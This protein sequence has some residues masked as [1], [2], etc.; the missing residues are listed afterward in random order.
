MHWQ[1][2]AGIDWFLSPE[3]WPIVFE[4][5]LGIGMV[6][7]VHELGHF[8]VAKACGVKCEKFYLGFDIGGWKLFKYKWG[9]TEYGIGVLPL[10][11]YVKMLGQDD[12]PNRLH[13]E[14][15]RAKLKSAEGEATADQAA[16][17]DSIFDPRSYLAK[18][19]PQ[20]MAI[21]SAGVIMNVIFAFVVGSIAFGLGVEQIACV[22]GK[23]F[24]GEPAWKAGLREGDTVVQIGDVKN[25]VFRDLQTG[26]ALG[27]NID[28]GVDFVVRRPGVDEP[29]K[30][31]IFP[32]R[33]KLIPL[34]GMTNGHTNQVALVLPGTFSTAKPESNAAGLKAGDR[35]VAVNGTKVAEGWQFDRALA[36]HP[37]TATLTV[38]RRQNKPS[39][40]EKKDQEPA[41]DRLEVELPAAPMRTLP[42][43][44]AMGKI[45]AVQ[46]G[47]PA[48]AADIRPD[49]LI[50]EIDGQDAGDPLRLAERLRQ[51]ED[52]AAKITI[53]RS[54][55]TLTKDV[56]LDLN[57]FDNTMPGDDSPV[58]IP[59]LGVAVA[60][61]N[62]VATVEVDGPAAAGGLKPGDTIEKVRLLPPDEEIQREKYGRKNLQPTKDIDFAKE[63][64]WPAVFSLLQQV[65]PETRV[66]LQ[67][68]DERTVTLDLTLSQDWFNRDRGVIFEPVLATQKA[69]TVAQAVALGWRESKYSLSLVFRF[70]R[71]LL[72]GQVSVKGIGGPVEIARQA[73]A[74]ASEGLSPFLLFLG[75]L[76]ANLAVLNFLPIP[77]LDGGHM[78]FLAAEG[79]R[80]KPVSERVVACFQFAGLFLL[81]SLMIFVLLLD[82]GLISRG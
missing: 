38:E 19:V 60:V 28:E 16:E 7:F 39:A 47:S 4:V 15:E 18:S 21:I 63:R 70:L 36:D 46:S 25:P 29:L 32:R 33:R 76:S 5:A 54:G 55:Q 57:A 73:G 35:V 74:T 12:N 17:G 59:A 53:V 64:N 58:A 40:D 48:E 78:V 23:V 24:A 10:G 50:K 30:F 43:A 45:E 80:G 37:G 6:I 1:L 14:T 9:E 66:E 69:D 65:L 27:D 81:A 56:A 49:D 8:A 77:M 22:V 75:M 82:V 61:E 13:E 44:M 11:G 34:I 3:N 62:Q 79:V 2:I 26:V 72:S 41:V 67:L 51:R 52:A 20:R 31:K 68:K 42:F 71:K